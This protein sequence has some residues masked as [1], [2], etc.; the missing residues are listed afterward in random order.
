VAVGVCAKPAFTDRY[1]SLGHAA[2]VAQVFPVAT[3]RAPTPAEAS[4]LVAKLTAGT[5]TR[6]A[7]MAALVSRPDSEARYRAQVEV[8]MTYAG[9]LR[10]RP[11]SSGWT[12]WVAKV[13]SGTSVQRL[14]A[15]FFASTEYR[16]RFAG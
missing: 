14:I 1:G 5:L 10:R 4:D 9:L 15:Q 11:D 13:A 2:F 16:R 3:G 12:Y 6:P 8:L 7:L